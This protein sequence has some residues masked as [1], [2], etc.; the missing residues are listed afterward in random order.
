MKKEI[1]KNGHR[2]HLPYFYWF[3]CHYPLITFFETTK[4]KFFYHLFE[5][6]KTKN[7][8]Y[9][10]EKHI[11]NEPKWNFSI[12]FLKIWLCFK[13]DGEAFCVLQKTRVFFCFYLF[14][15]TTKWHMNW[16]DSIIWAAILVQQ[17]WKLVNGN[18]F[19]EVLMKRPNNVLRKQP[20][21]TV[22]RI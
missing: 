6:T 22:S 13:I 12:T 8:Y 14:W 10:F 9:F 19:W 3:Q 17:H 21:H 4:S 20:T 18:H 11:E 16:W 5:T 1:E 2:R 7:F 15:G